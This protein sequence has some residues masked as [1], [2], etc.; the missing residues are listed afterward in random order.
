MKKN[1]IHV[2]YIEDKWVMKEENNDKESISFDTKDEAIEYSKKKA[3]DNKVE[4]IIHNIDNK[5][6]NRNSYGNYPYPPKG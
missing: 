5:I 6:S 1:N 2:L 4:L 3:K